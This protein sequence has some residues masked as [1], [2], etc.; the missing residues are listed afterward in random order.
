MANS[1]PTLAGA[2]VSSASGQDLSTDEYTYRVVYTDDNADLSVEGTVIIG[3][4]DDIADDMLEED[5]SDTNVLD[6]KTYLF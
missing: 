4:T 6:G 3:G 5:P 2:S 1:P